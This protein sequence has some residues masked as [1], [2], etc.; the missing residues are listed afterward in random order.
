MATDNY[1]LMKK[2][3]FAANAFLTAC[4]VG[5]LFVYMYF[6][7]TWM[8]NISIPVT[9]L[10]VLF[11]VLISY[12][13]IDLYFW[14]VYATIGI[15]MCTAT[16]CLGTNFGFNLYCMSLIPIG[17]FCQYLS[18]KLNSKDIKTGYSCIALVI[19]YFVSIGIVLHNGP[20]Y[21]LDKKAETIFYVMNSLFVFVFLIVYSALLVNLVI[22]SE[23]KL[24]NMALY[25]NLTGLY[26]R[27]CIIEK[28]AEMESAKSIKWIA[29]VDV[30]KFKVINDTYGHSAGDEVLKSI[31][32]LMRDVCSECYISRWGGEEFLLVAN[33]A[34]SLEDS[35]EALR[36]RVEN[37]DFRY[38]DEVIRATVSAGATYYSDELGVE[39]CIQVA[40]RNL[41]T[42]KNNGRNR[43]TIG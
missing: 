24:E 36:V 17:F 27:H 8:V 21:Q 43:I 14:A 34:N 31:A 1:K 25:D 12:N 4:V 18:Y 6:D 9:V 22:S 11:F 5:M 42:S 7:V 39:E 41:Y 10:Y 20:L 30:D 15:Y 38:E 13:R 23:K 3:S 19:L 37:N 2:L 33:K 29:I 32:T 28:L 26:N 40:D 35:L 16:V